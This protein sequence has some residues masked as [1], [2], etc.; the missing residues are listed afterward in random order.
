MI[1]F[2]NSRMVSTCQELREELSFI[3]RIDP[4]RL[5][6]QRGQELVELSV[7]VR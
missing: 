3:D 6:V 5:T 1:L 2:V 7:T 4:L